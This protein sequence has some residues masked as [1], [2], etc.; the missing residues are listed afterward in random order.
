MPDAPRPPPTG[1]QPRDVYHKE[2]KAH[3]HRDQLDSGSAVTRPARR[4]EDNPA[5]TTFLASVRRF[6]AVSALMA[7]I[8]LIALKGMN[9]MDRM[10]EE[11]LAPPPDEGRDYARE[12]MP[13]QAPATVET[14]VPVNPAVLGDEPRPTG[15]EA[16]RQA[17]FLTT[18]AKD[19]EAE[20]HYAEAL[21][22]YR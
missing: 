12:V 14:T 7:V 4:N 11:R 2:K 13:A 5:R 6:A 3:R 19:L 15:D 17:A 18:R 22:R 8:L 10:Y 20:G 21:E 16:M 1:S 9:V